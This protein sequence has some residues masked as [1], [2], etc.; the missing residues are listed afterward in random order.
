MCVPGV[1]G[2]PAGRPW[3]GPL[4]RVGGGRSPAGTGSYATAQ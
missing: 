3:R 1:P 2:S 4:V